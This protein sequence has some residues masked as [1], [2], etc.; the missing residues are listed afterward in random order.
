MWVYIDYC[1]QGLAPVD[2]NQI[3]KEEIKIKKINGND[4]YCWDGKRS[5][6]NVDVK[7]RIKRNIF[8]IV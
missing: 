4:Y 3:Y 2:I 7:V 5:K 1:F 6:T 8:T